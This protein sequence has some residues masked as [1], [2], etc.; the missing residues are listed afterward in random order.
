MEAVINVDGKDHVYDHDK[1]PEIVVTELTVLQPRQPSSF[2]RRVKSKHH[3]GQDNA[4]PVSCEVIKWSLSGEDRLN[5]QVTKSPRSSLKREQKDNESDSKTVLKTPCKLKDLTV[6]E[7]S[8]CLREI[9]LERY[10]EKFRLEGINGKLFEG[11]DE[12]SLLELDV[13][14]QKHQE[15]ILKLAKEKEYR[16]KTLKVEFSRG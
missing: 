2:E 1:P 11:L 14:D 7:I 8:E 5:V 13:E 9:G 10:V 15:K 16:P 6:D 12:D 4:Q 3:N